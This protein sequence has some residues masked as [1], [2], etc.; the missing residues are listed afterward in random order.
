MKEIHRPVI[1]TLHRLASIDVK[2]QLEKTF[3]DITIRYPVQVSPGF[4]LR[5][6]VE[7]DPAASFHRVI[8]HIK[9]DGE[10]TL[11]YYFLG[12]TEFA[13][14]LLYFWRWPSLLDEGPLRCHWV[15]TPEGPW[16]LESQTLPSD[17][18]NYRTLFMWPAST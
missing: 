7:W 5:S 11:K 1:R 17:I 8:L 14:P 6:P 2:L 12:F 15:P 9:R 16:K 4:T 13:E 18:S 10:P 3:P